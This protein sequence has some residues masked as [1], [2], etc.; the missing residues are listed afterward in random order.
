M[1]HLIHNEAE[2]RLGKAYNIAEF[3]R[4]IVLN[5]TDAERVLDTYVNRNMEFHLLS[6]SLT[7]KLSEMFNEWIEAQAFTRDVLK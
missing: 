2:G 3:T 6:N 1:H 5:T 7:T 4:L